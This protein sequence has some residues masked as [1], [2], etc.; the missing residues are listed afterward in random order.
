[1]VWGILEMVNARAFKP[2]S[3]CSAK[4]GSSAKVCVVVCKSYLLFNVGGPLAKG[5]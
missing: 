2:L 5:G 3:L 4:V 1:M